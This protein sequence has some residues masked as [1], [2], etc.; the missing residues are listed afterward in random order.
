MMLVISAS[1]YAEAASTWAFG[2]QPAFVS[3]TKRWFAANGLAH[4][5]IVEP[6]GIDPHNTSTPSDMIALGKLAMANPVKSL[7]TE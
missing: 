5:K 2:S 4:T 3:A 7:R 6:T 1:N